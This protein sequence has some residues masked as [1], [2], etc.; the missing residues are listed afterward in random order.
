MVIRKDELINKI[1]YARQILNNSIDSRER[2]E[3]IYE[4][5]VKLDLLIEQYIVAGF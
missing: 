4:K 1:E 5:S 2:Y 3:D